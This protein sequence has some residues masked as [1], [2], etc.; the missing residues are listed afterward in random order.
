V[1]SSNAQV[2]RYF[3]ER[4]VGIVE[5]LWSRVALQRTNLDVGFSAVDFPGRFP[6]KPGES[7]GPRVGRASIAMDGSIASKR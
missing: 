1:T 4:V 3:L 6:R 5:V 2:R 7:G